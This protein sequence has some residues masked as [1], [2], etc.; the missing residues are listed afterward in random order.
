MS[1]AAPVCQTVKP[2]AAASPI[3]RANSPPSQERATNRRVSSSG[4]VRSGA[5]IMETPRVDGGK[6]RL[7]AY[8]GLRR[9][10]PRGAAVS[11][12]PHGSVRLVRVS[13]TLALVGAA[14]RLAPRRGWRR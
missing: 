14:K 9:V 6:F 10:L 8:V 3:A 5:Y 1:R 13:E 2:A 7:N 4:A 11:S 12:G